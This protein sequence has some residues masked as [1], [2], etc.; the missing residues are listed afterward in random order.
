[1]VPVITFSTGIRPEDA[2]L[3]MRQIILPLAKDASHDAVESTIALASSIS[4]SVEGCDD[5]PRVLKELHSDQPNQ[6][7]NIRLGDLPVPVRPFVAN[8][9]VG[10]ATEPMRNDSFVR[11]LVLCKRVDQKATIPTPDEMRQTLLNRR[12]EQLSRR[13]LRDLR[14]DAI[15]E[16]R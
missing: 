11:I 10:K 1:M 12:L 8:L 5:V 15:V 9:E 3:T 2:Q 6:D 4:Q 13:Y 16:I 7:I 14:R